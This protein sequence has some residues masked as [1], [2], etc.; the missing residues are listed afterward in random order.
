[1]SATTNAAAVTIAYNPGTSVHFSNLRVPAT[2]ATDSAAYGSSS[3]LRLSSDQN[4]SPS[5]L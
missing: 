2:A 4:L 5:S 3:S 1:V